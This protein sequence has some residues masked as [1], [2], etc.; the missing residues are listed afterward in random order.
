MKKLNLF[1]L[2]IVLILTNVVSAIDADP[3]A[4][5]TNNVPGLTFQSWEF[6]DP[7]NPAPPSLESNVYGI[8]DCDI[9]NGEFTNNL[10][11]PDGSGPPVSGWYFPI[12][13]NGIMLMI[14]NDPA[15]NPEK[16]I[17]IQIT[18]TKSP[19]S[20]AINI[21]ADNPPLTTNYLTYSAAWQ[22]SD[23]SWYTYVY[24]Y[25]V[26]PNPDS[27]NINITF[28]ANTIVE[29]IVVDTWCL[30][31]PS[32]LIILLSVLFFSKIRR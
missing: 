23:A 8:V 14:P 18:S 32:F 21:T 29:E 2:I 28:L 7:S 20:D 6:M 13:D 15:P 11:N 30:P 1:L 17:R 16:K 12:E 27:E 25:H 22:H 24:E 31:E 19:G 5:R 10:P 9:H 3:P 4:W 26:E